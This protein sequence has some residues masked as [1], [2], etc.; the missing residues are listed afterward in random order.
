MRLLIKALL[1]L[2]AS[3]AVI[4][5][6]GEGPGYLLIQVGGYT[7]ETTAALGA[8]ALILLL[9]VGWELWG[10]LSAAWH[11][12]GTLSRAREQRHQRRSL[13][14]LEQGV[15]ALERGE[16]DRARKLLVRGGRQ[17]KDPGAFYVEAARAAH[18]AGSD[19]RAEE[20]L[21]LAQKGDRAD[22]PATTLVRAEME[23][24]AGREEH[25]LALLSELEK[26]EAENPQVVRRLLALNRKVED[27]DALLRLL[28]RAKKLGVVKAEAAD[29]ELR[30]VRGRRMEEAR[31]EGDR[32]TVEELWKDAD[33][34]ERARPALVGPW[35]RYLLAEGR[36]EEAEKALDH[37]LKREWQGELVELYLALPEAPG[38]AQELLNRLEKWVS[39]RPR[40]P[41]L[42][43]VLAQLAVGAQLW[44]KADHY[45]AEASALEEIPANLLLRLASIYQE[46]ERPDQA[47]DC[48]RR[49]L[50]SLES[51]APALPSPLTPP[52]T[53]ANSG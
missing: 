16:A 39:D 27:W 9:A 17:A 25:A 6:L 42:L 7:L 37:A 40:D 46:R 35:I 11:L 48:L 1:V 34:A 10:M 52:E 53:A 28:P 19:E 8:L 49:G 50:Y 3:V 41:Y 23:M 30:E 33:R 14:A 43:T 26:R 4:T 18:Q 2:A 5:L 15:L 32:A 51:N 21:A 38:S 47:L 20:Y 24:D 13:D 22:D 36:R 31:L 44:G 29:A 12:P 45:L